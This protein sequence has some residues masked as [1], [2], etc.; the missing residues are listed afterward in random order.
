M[1]YAFECFAALLGL[2]LG[3]FL[4]IGVFRP[5]SLF[6]ALPL[7]AVRVYAVAALLGAGTVLAGIVARPCNPILMA[8][9]LRLFAVVL[10]VY[11]AAVFFI[12][13]VAQAGITAL[14]FTLLALLA[15]LRSFYLR[16]NAE[17]AYRTHRGE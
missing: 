3:A 17:A 10:V 5:G 16:A 7:I 14:F 6:L 2:L 9:G 1:E 12:G 8:V 11:G 4:L 15:W 13:G